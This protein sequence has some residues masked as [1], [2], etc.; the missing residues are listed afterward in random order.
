MVETSQ[1]S[2]TDLS[3]LERILQTERENERRLR[4]AE[5]AAA[6]QV[7][8]ARQQAAAIK[9]QEA[10]RGRQQGQAEYDAILEAARQEAEQIVTQARDRATALRADARSH[11]PAMVER[12]LALVLGEAGVEATIGPEE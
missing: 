1:Q 4:L 3:P 10:E 5:E 11:L 9:A 6:A 7:A 2:D 8:R 12:I